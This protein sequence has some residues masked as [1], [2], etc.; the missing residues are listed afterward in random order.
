[1]AAP[2]F[3]AE[4]P[5]PAAD[6]VPDAPALP[7]ALEPEAEAPDPDPDE[8]DPVAEA[9]EPEAEPD[10]APDAVMPAAAAP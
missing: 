5:D 3:E 4:A 7:V 1:M 9:D 6:A 8:A 10:D 2:D